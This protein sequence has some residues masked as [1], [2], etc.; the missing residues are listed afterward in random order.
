MNKHA[1]VVIDGDI[2]SATL[3]TQLIDDGYI[4][5][6]M[7]FKNELTNPKKFEAISKFVSEV[8]VEHHMI[9]AM[10]MTYMFE[11][12]LTEFLYQ[13]TFQIALAK[14][15][16]ADIYFASY[17]GDKYNNFP[18]AISKSI[19]L[20][21]EK[22]VRLNV[23][24]LRMT[25]SQVISIGTKLNTKYDLTWSCENSED[26]PCRQCQSCI[27]RHDAFIVQNTRDLGSPN[28][29]LAININAYDNR[30]K[31]ETSPRIISSTKIPDVQLPDRVK[32]TKTPL[33]EAAS[34]AITSI[35]RDPHIEI[36]PEQVEPA[37][38]I[39]VNPE[40]KSVNLHPVPEGTPEVLEP[41]APITDIKS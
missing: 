11:D 6:V 2:A 31:I 14:Q 17:R 19:Y 28:S 24:Y 20:G 38:K 5:H 4:V 41:S 30:S 16:G 26:E 18:A 23:P 35:Q 34:D 32:V 12:V 37:V 25:L 36:P 13:L 39:P 33:K 3:I 15:L 21:S 29:D 1:V 22:A 27:D 40:P 10:T 7:S 8:K 9:D